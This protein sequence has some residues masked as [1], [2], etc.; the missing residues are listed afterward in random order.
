MGSRVHSNVARIAVWSAIP[1]LGLAIL[2]Y[3]WLTRRY[4][5]PPISTVFKAR[6]FEEL[7]G[8]WVLRGHDGACITDWQEIRFSRDHRVMTIRSSR[9]DERLD[10]RVDSVANYDVRV[11]TPRS[12]RAV[13]RDSA[14]LTPDGRPVVWD[15]ALRSGNRM[16][17]HR[18]DWPASKYAELERCPDLL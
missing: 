13:I 4:I 2:G 5:I 15:L 8:R 3:R 6:V 1:L 9:Q 11:L 14:G 7:E 18:A 16:A 12:I 17:R 10:A